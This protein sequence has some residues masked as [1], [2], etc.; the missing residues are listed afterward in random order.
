MHE[1]IASDQKVTNYHTSSKIGS[2]AF[3]LSFSFV[4][5]EGTFGEK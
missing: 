2:L 1:N 5:L 4:F 3:A